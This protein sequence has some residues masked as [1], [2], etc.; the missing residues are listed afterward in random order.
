MAAGIYDFFEN[1]DRLGPGSA[2]SLRWA[3]DLAGVPRDG[4][5][6]DAGCGTGADL[7]GLLA[8]VPEGRVVAIDTAETFIAR[9]RQRF[10]AVTAAVADM[11]APPDGPYDLI[12]SAGAVYQVGV[13]R[14]LGAWRRHLKPGGRV[15]F[16]DLCWTLDDRPPE[17]VAFW[18][19]EGLNPGDAAALEAE[20]EAAG[21]RVLGARWLG[22]ADWAA[23]YG[24]VEVEL[25]RFG[26]ESA[27]V[28]GFR[29]EIAIWRT[30]GVSFGYRL[31]V[32]EPA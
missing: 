26:D 23:Y 31:I 2:A 20:V 7:G 14:A 13:G 16:S 8:A 12:W 11:T 19:E 27:L 6:L 25:D 1:L 4:V 18:A 3:L 24:P 10:P 22:P 32:A 29:R 21:Y 30:H 28:A 9:V 5:I 15:V 17:A